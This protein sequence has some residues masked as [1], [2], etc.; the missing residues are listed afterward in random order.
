MLPDWIVILPPLLV[1]AGVLLTKRMIPSFIV[2][3]LSAAL[4]ATK[5]NLLKAVLLL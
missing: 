4:I 5:G 3:I 1:V 2:G